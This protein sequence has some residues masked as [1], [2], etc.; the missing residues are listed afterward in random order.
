[1]DFIVDWID[2]WIDDSS[3]DDEA[4]N[5]RMVDTMVSLTAVNT[6]CARLWYS[7]RHCW[8]GVPPLLEEEVLGMVLLGAPLV[9]V[10]GVGVGS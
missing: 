1:M 2:D 10:A 6:G 7:A 8:V 4:R 3:D 9:A 5:D